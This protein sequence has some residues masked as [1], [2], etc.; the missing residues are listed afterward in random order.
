MTYLSTILPQVPRS[1]AKI[2]MCSNKTVR[3]LNH[4]VENLIV[5]HFLVGSCI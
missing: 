2:E 5:I 3:K 1:L 4:F